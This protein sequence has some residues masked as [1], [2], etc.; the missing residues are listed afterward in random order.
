MLLV[1][2]PLMVSD[3]LRVEYF[4]IWLFADQS[5]LPQLRGTTCVPRITHS[6]VR[7]ELGNHSLIRCFRFSGVLR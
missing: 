7:R 5:L 4:D 1:T 3:H 2:I 6:S